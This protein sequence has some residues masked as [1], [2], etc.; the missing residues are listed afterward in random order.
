[1]YVECRMPVLRPHV[2]K[3]LTLRSLLE[4]VDALKERLE[5][6]RTREEK[7]TILMEFRFLLDAADQIVRNNP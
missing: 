2:A 6:S 5:N 7:Q 3:D 4:K 1:M